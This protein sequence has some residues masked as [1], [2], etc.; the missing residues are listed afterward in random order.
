MTGLLLRFPKK[1]LSF[2]CRSSWSTFSTV[3]FLEFGWGSVQWKTATRQKLNPSS[4]QVGCLNTTTYNH[5]PYIKGTVPTLCRQTLVMK[6]Q[7]VLDALQP[8]R[9]KGLVKVLPQ[10]SNAYVKT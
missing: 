8:I 1:S 10:H 7:L 9:N 2:S 4:K 6:T 3:A 5:E